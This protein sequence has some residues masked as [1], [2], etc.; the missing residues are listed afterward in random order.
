MKKT[1]IFTKRVTKE[2]LR[3]PVIY[4][5]G[6]G[7][8]LIMLFLFAVINHFIQGDMPVFEMKSLIPGI[9]VFSAT[10]IMMSMTLMVS[11]DRSTSLL[12]RLYTSPLKASNFIIGY[13]T[14]GII[15]GIFQMI[16]CILGG[17]VFSIIS[18]T[19]YFNFGQALLLM[20]VD[21][22]NLIICV[23][24]GILFGTILNEKSG[25]GIVSVF[26]SASGILGGCWMPLDTMG[27]FENI[28][29]FFPFYPSVSLGRIVTKAVHTNLEV[30]RFD[31]TMIIGLIV[32]GIYLLL[33]I[34]LSILLF[35]KQMNS[36]N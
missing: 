3:D 27:S 22:P 13:A 26:I 35:K 33:S 17:F 16:I 32:I 14:P 25:P 4:I 31:N 12:K 9:L 21:I 10:F 36:E 30:Y 5:F 6:I 20:L 18:G 34:L 23:F 28:C 7:F 11:K 2:I 29:R 19:D 1:L 8:P 24:L 15:L